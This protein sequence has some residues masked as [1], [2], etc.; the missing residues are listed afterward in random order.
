[1][2]AKVLKYLEKICES[3][4]DTNSLS[5]HE[6]VDLL[7]QMED[8]TDHDETY[9][10]SSESDFSE[11]NPVQVIQRK[12][13]SQE[14]NKIKKKSK[15]IVDE[16][17]EADLDN[18]SKTENCSQ[19]QSVVHEGELSDQQIE[20]ES[21]KWARKI[22]KERK[23]KMHTGKAYTNYRGREEAARELKPLKE[24]R[25]RCYQFLVEEVRTAIF[26]EY[27]SLGSRD[28]RVAFIAA[29]T[30]S[31][32]VLCNRKRKPES[33]KSRNITYEYFFQIKG[34]RHVVCKGCFIKTLDEKE[35]FILNALKNKSLSMSGI[36]KPDQR[37]KLASVNKK[38]KNEIEQVR[39]HIKSFPSFE[40]HYTRRTN[41][42]KY[43]PSHLN[44]R[45]MYDLYCEKT[46]KP[47][48]RKIYERE[49]HNMKLFFKKPKVDTC[50]KCDVL[51][52]KIK[53]ASEASDDKVKSEAEYELKMHHEAAD[54]AY[55]AK[56][57]DKEAAKNNE[58][59][60]CFVFDLQQ[61]LPTPFVCT[62]VAFYKRQLWTFNLTIHNTTT[63]TSTHYMWHEGLAGRGANEIASCVYRHLSTIPEN[64]KEVTFYSDTCG[65]QNRN[66]HL[67]A[68]F[69]KAMAD[70]PNFN[71][72]HHKFL[73]PGHSHM[74]CDVDH[75]LIEKRKKKLS[76]PIFHPH[77]WFQL[78]RTTGK[79]QQFTVCEM[80]QD[81]FFDFSGL[82]KTVLVNRKKN[83]EG[84]PF[85]WHS[86][87]WL[88]YSKDEG[89]LYYKE[90]LDE[91]EF[92]QVSFRRRG[93]SGN[94]R[95]TQLKRR[96]SEMVAISEEKKKDLIDLLPLVPPVFH[97]FYLKLKT[98][99]DI[100][101]VDPD[102]EEINYD[103]PEDK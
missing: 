14:K 84:T 22:G 68:M 48:S 55:N 101:D 65:G 78:V 39:S 29:H 90:Y 3:D 64:V 93:K 24:C 45:I 103:D 54:G 46:D 43:L 50:H 23:E 62:S 52:M 13:K 82:L 57:I 16:T 77:D 9:R 92:K 81:N 89:I 47:V 71:V 25:K 63:G 18:I 34:V 59:K 36:T 56:R 26:D 102:L 7:E 76:M 28:K 19:R 31:K 44:L 2:D 37:G 15:I 51:T 70:F 58:N 94:I 33:L 8:D 72:I 4:S 95:D 74:E 75:G 1:M 67:S 73:I 5:P 97:D 83:I 12:P 80:T 42:K 100:V 30:T 96:Y 6:N 10:P 53:V 98:A 85:K 86:V 69:L 35:K 87:R 91:S 60:M 17:D 79:K 11:E 27:W 61:C 41:D 21:K 66:S 88:S 40:S 20:K 38:T 49:F 99:R 32:E